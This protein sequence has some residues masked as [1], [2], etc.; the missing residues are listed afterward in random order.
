VYVSGDPATLARD[1]KRL[2]KH[3]YTLGAVQPI[4]L[5]PQTYYIDA[6]ATFTL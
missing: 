4:D 1:A 6:V 2:A 3:G 5:N